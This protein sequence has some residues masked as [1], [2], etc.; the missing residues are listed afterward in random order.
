[1]L[2]IVKPQDFCHAAEQSNIFSTFD[3]SLVAF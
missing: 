1:M 2:D 3:R